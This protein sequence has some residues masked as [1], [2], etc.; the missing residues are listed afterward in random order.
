LLANCGAEAIECLEQ[1]PDI[2]LVITDKE[3]PNM[4]GLAL[5]NEIRSKYSKDEVSIIGVSGADNPH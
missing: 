2:K 3:M 5:C 1:Q 4:D